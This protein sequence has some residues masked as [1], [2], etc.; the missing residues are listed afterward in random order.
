MEITNYYAPIGS[1]ITLVMIH[2]VV[3]NSCPPCVRRGALG[4]QER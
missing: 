1:E 3:S 4:D 2:Q